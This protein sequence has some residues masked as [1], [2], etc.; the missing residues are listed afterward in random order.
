MTEP[1]YCPTCGASVRVV[2]ELEGTSFYVPTGDPG[3]DGDATNMAVAVKFA[4]SVFG[5]A[6]DEPEHDR[7][8]AIGALEGALSAHQRRLFEAGR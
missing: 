5:R 8:T 3:A 2:A 4:L 6:E 1:D 7:A